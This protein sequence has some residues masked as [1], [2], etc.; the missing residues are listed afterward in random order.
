[1]PYILKEDLQ[2][3]GMALHEY[4][5]ERQKCKFEGPKTTTI[6]IELRVTDG[7]KV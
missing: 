3:R 7:A 5:E 1:M 6:T 4:S 2:A